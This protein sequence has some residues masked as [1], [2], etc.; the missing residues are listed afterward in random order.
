MR[1][2]AFE[3]RLVHRSA[4]WTALVAVSTTALLSISSTNIRDGW[5]ADREGTLADM[6]PGAFQRR[7]VHSQR[8]HIGG[9]VSH[10]RGHVSDPFPAISHRRPRVGHP[11]PS[12]GSLSGV[13]IFT[14]PIGKEPLN[15]PF[16]DA[17]GAAA[18]QRRLVHHSAGRT[19]P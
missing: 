6:R 10:I 14:M 8:C 5:L 15:Y 16:L 9:P 11:R 17:N 13:K 7:L 12:V 3:R 4:G 18:F 1:F 2:V 19:H